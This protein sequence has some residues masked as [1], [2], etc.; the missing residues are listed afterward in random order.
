MTDTWSSWGDVIGSFAGCYNGNSISSVV[1]RLCLAACVYL[2]WQERNN[3]LFRDEN[4]SVDDLFKR[5][6]DIVKMRLASLKMRKSNA[7]SE[8]ERVWDVKLNMVSEIGNGL[9]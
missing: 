4:R 1:R 9:I 2:V 8:T 3:R 6:C 7:V 5:F